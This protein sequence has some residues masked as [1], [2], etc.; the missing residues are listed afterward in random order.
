M[1]DWRNRTAAT[2]STDARLV[3]LHGANGS[4]KTNLLEAV[5]VLASLRSFRD[6]RPARWVREGAGAAL[7]E[8]RAS[9]P[10]GE[11]LMAYKQV[12]GERSLSV[13]GGPASLNVWFDALRAILFCP[14][15]VNVIRG[16]PEGR[17][18]LLDR[19]VFTARPAFLDL[20]RDYKRVVAQRGAL[21][22]SGR[23][24]GAEL[25]TWDERLVNLG[26]AV[27]LRRHQLVEELRAPLQEAVRLISGGETVELR[28][29][30][31]GGEAE[32]EETVRSRL[33][34]ALSR[35][36]PEELRLGTV[37]VGPHRDD[38][39]ITIDGRSARRFA[40]QGQARTVALALKLGELEAARLRG[41]SP[42]FLLD[43]LTS[44]LDIGRRGRLISHLMSLQ[45]QVWVTTT[46]ASYLGPLPEGT[47]RRFRITADA[48]QEDS[49]GADMRG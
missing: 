46:E 32:G 23:A 41:Q 3:V 15:Q 34:D 16:E 31:A 38:L 27:M 6:A 19:A 14:E 37:L 28:L 29:R 43:D 1:A 12:D 45:S 7:I 21:L 11:R 39:E 35:A 2:L 42:L 30:S 5:Y 10:H 26:A 22:R 24:G 36:R 48:V 17:R 9:G 13:D 20:A 25:E 8:G 4:G 33:R 40:S 18:R 49:D 44:E 47:S